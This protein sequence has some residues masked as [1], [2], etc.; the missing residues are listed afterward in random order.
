MV[1]YLPYQRAYINGIDDEA[2][3]NKHHNDAGKGGS[4]MVVIAVR[5]S[6]KGN[7]KTSL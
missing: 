3:S 2:N 1:Q 6:T 4:D 5:W 7:P